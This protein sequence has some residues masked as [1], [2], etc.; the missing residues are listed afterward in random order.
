MRP[1]W[2]TTRRTNTPD[3]VDVSLTNIIN[4]KG[5]AV[6][7]VADGIHWTNLDLEGGSFA[8]GDEIDGLG[9]TTTATKS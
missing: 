9:S 4:A 8:K 1:R 6:S 7:R 2:P 3:I 5:T